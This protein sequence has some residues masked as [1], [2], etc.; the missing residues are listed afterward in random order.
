[1]SL[2]KY[3][4]S[5]VWSYEFVVH[6]QRVRESTGTKNKE[7]ARDIELN[8]KHAIKHGAPI[9]M[10]QKPKQFSVDAKTW[11]DIKSVSLAPNSVKIAEGCLVHLK[12]AFGKQLSCDI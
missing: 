9:R 12:T 7:E 8:R 6:G 11:L 10:R 2:F 3:P 1:M 5:S 4:G